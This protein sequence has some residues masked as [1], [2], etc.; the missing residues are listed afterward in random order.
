MKSEEFVE[1]GKLQ[2]PH[3]IKGEI[4]ATIDADI[5]LE[6]LTYI[7]TVIDGLNVPFFINSLRPRSSE[8]VLLTLEGIDN[9]RDAAELSLLPI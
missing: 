2:K 7:V 9:E 3:G 8:S 6:Q 5:D 4:V 1:I